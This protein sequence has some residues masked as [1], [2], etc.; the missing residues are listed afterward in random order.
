MTNQLLHMDLEERRRLVEAVEGAASMGQAPSASRA[1]RAASQGT[2]AN[3]TIE[4]LALEWRGQLLEGDR[5][6]LAK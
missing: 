1:S 6:L 5:A 3:Q 4:S 2:D